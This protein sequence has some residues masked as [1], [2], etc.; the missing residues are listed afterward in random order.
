MT[1]ALAPAELMLRAERSARE[2]AAAQEAISARL[3]METLYRLAELEFARILHRYLG[4]APVLEDIRL[5]WDGATGSIIFRVRLADGSDYGAR[6]D[7]REHGREFRR[8][9]VGAL[10]DDQLIPELH[11]RYHEMRARELHHHARAR[12]HDVRAVDLR[13]GAITWVDPPTATEVRVAQ[14]AYEARL[15]TATLQAMRQMEDEVFRITGIADGA[16]TTPAG[17][18]GT[19]TTSS[20]VP[21][22]FALA[23]PFTQEQVEEFRR[24]QAEEYERANKAAQRG[25]ALLKSWLS[26]E[27]LEQY[28]RNRHFDVIGSL[29][30]RYRI[31][32]SPSY[33]V[34]QIDERGKIVACFCFQPQG[35]LCPGDNMLAQKIALETDEGEAIKVANRM[36]PEALAIVGAL[37]PQPLR[38]GSRFL[39]WL[40]S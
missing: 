23:L 24:Q 35:Y 33:N 10:T 38:R 15:R 18:L 8:L 6:W 27:Q 9:H 11:R 5:D 20:Y 26:K 17:T 1:P 30:T 13:P 3:T 40:G 25:M 22:G 39:G 19:F 14:A 32:D 28:E 7:H 36:R 34:R 37:N 31:T 21:G 2:V 29:G 4:D 16:Y 12:Q